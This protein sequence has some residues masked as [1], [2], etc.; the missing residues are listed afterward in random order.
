MTETHEHPQF[1]G[2]RG[3]GAL[4]EAARPSHWIKNGFV[5]APILFSGR[6]MEAAAWALCLAAATAFC[7]L[8]SG[9]YLI[10]DLC[11]RRRDRAHPLKRLR[12]VASGRLSTAT[13][14][15]V[16]VAL[17]AGGLAVAAATALAAPEGFWRGATAHA[18][19][20][21]WGVVVW[22]AGYVVLNGFYSFWLKRHPI[23]DVIAV[24]MGFVLRA[25]AGAAAI[26]V[27]ISPWLVVCTFA[28]CL[29]IALTKRRA[30]IVDLPDEDLATARPV[31]VVYS[32]AGL[33][34]ML[35]VSASMALLTYT[36]YSLAPATVQRIG[37]AHM[38][39]TVP[40]VVYGLFRFNLLS[41]SSGGDPVKVLI[42]DW[43]MWAVIFI[44]A[45]LVAAVVK[46]GGS[47]HV[48]SILE[49]GIGS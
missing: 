12:P 4:W 33:D 44:Y 47:E 14:A 2:P 22:A 41:R 11:D 13:A 9:V 46:C 25:M 28:L 20:G 38:V 43:A 49:P 19:L 17:L 3:L 42:R 39:W 26:A 24:A 27:P 18:P 29:F 36:L 10:N 34:V 31:N 1:A 7:M 16:G 48:R 15:T 45:L 40:V 23:V 35:T 30:E 32:R 37:S 6:F 5:A 21:G 8:S